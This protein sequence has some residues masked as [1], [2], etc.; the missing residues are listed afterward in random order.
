MRSDRSSDGG[1][2][3]SHLAADK[4]GKRR[5][6]PKLDATFF[7]KFCPASREF[8]FRQK[9]V[10]AGNQNIERKVSSPNPGIFGPKIGEQEVAPHALGWRR[11]MCPLPSGLRVLTTSSTVLQFSRI[12]RRKFRLLACV[13]RSCSRV[14]FRPVTLPS[15]HSSATRIT[16]GNTGTRHGSRNPRFLQYRFRYWQESLRYAMLIRCY[17]LRAEPRLSDLFGFETT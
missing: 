9:R 13:C 5:G 12:V 2:N 8:E 7:A 14:S 11:S 15:L 16:L 1:P 6:Q 17:L 10:D 4:P 3:Q